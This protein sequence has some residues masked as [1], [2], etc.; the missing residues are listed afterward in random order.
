MATAS[1]P[2]WSAPRA[3][4]LGDTGAVNHAA[5]INQ[6]L[7]L[8]ADTAIY[9]GSPILTPFGTGEPDWF[10]HLDAYDL[11][12]P[13]AM[14][15]TTIG[16]VTI[17]LLP[18]GN[19]SD[20]TVGLYADNSG[21][22]GT[23]ITQTRIPASWVSQLAAV[24]GA[25][26]ASTSLNL[27]YTGNPLAVAQ[28]NALHMGNTSTF[29]WPY[30]A[31]GTGGPAS[32]PISTYYP[33]YFIQ[34]G[35]NSGSTFYNSVYTIAYDSAGNLAAAIPQP[36]LPAT[37]D[38][39]GAAVV[40]TDPG[41]G[42]LT[43]VVAG[44]SQVSGGG[45]VNA[46]YTASFNA[47]TGVIASWS[48]QTALPA[49][50]QFHAMAAWNGYVYAIGGDS[51]NVY[52][53]QVQNGQIT[54]WNA[55]TPI[56]PGVTAIVSR[57]FM[58]AAAIDGFLYILGGF[59]GVALSIVNYAS[60]NPDGS[61]GAWQNGPSFPVTFDALFGL[62]GLHAGSYGIAVNGSARLMMLG[63]TANGPDISWQSAN[64]PTGGNFFALADVGPGQWR[65]YGLNATSYITMLVSLT[66]RVSVP[67]PAAGLTN[68]GTYHVVMSQSAGDL[69]NYLRTSDD[70]D[71][72]PG[73]PT[74]LTRAEGSSSWVAGA[75]NHAVP[76]AIYDNSASGRPW[77]TW[78]DG[79]AS[80]GTLVYAT[81]PDQ[82]LIGIL[83]ATSQPGPVLNQN[84]T[85][86]AG[87]APW[88]A[89]GGSVARSAAHTQGGLPFSAL[90]T[91][92]G[93]AAQT[94]IQSEQ[95]PVQQGHSYTAAAWLYS[96]VGYSNA[97]VDINWYTSASS[98]VS[99][100]TGAT[101]VLAA[102]T[103]TQITTTGA[104][105]ATA[106]YGTIVPVESGTPPVTAVFYVSPATLQDTSGPMLSCVSEINY[107]GTWPGS[108]WPPTGVTQLA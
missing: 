36:S 93:S 1:T 43:L 55:T 87:L 16:R 31:S 94:Y 49:T 96:P 30:P 3:G 91:P 65:Y 19:G 101:T 85:F 6:H 70:F 63:V 48:A 25:A 103:W 76:I 78:D 56:P 4:L 82:R 80:I 5:Q 9:Q 50:N 95:I 51:N 92:T 62:P 38:G 105:P 72:F 54:S 73:N 12:Q 88:A 69:N 13:F 39:S 22:P 14:S 20:L 57:G 53:A 75:T 83:E 35:G 108:A 99:T 77:H 17:P 21:V 67:L 15:G 52:Y 7:G 100:T 47:A 28:F 18:V 64:S 41:S 10:Y 84:P 29:S 44:G 26:Q 42:A 40:S 46:V 45:A 86:T 71:V 2:A 23:L 59:N 8:H 104:V 81:T 11:A 37:T 24:S 33:G 97:T 58:C 98:L 66:P 68:G 107:S 89:T 90:V 74:V 106:A 61:L 79:G 102:G 27:Q 34:L 60:I 32:N